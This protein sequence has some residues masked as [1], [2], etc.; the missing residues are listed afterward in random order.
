MDEHSIYADLLNQSIPVPMPKGGVLIFDS[1]IFHAR[2]KNTTEGTRM[3][4]TMGYHSVDELSG[5]DDSKLMLV[6][7][8]RLYKGND[9][10]LASQE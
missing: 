1:L 7:G 10:Y 2:G 9:T 3:T 8:E 6:H 5:K 4:A